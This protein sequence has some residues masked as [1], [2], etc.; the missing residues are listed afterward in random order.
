MY[1]RGV[2]QLDRLWRDAAKIP[3]VMAIS[4]HPYITG[5]PHRIDAFEKLLD[6]VLAKP[7]VKVMTGEKIAD[8]YTSQVPAS[9]AFK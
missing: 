8:W 5:V 7:E 2:L 9:A 6:A 1:H 4:V 3:R